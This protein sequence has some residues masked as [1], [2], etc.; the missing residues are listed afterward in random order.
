MAV[1]DTSSVGE[2][3]ESGMVSCCGLPASAGGGFSIATW[4]PVSVGNGGGAG[5]S[6]CNWLAMSTTVSKRPK[7]QQLPAVVGGHPAVDAAL[8]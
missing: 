5:G 6:L 4:R 2:L 7:I 3:L 8:K 1:W